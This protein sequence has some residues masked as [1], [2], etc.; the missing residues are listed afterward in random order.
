MKK[1]G[2]QMNY[3][4]IHTKE[5]RCALK[6]EKDQRQNDEVLPK[7]TSFL[8]LDPENSILP[9]Q[10]SR[11]LVPSIKPNEN[12]EKNRSSRSRLRTMK[13]KFKQKLKRTTN[14]QVEITSDNE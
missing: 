14:E 6:Y 10:I 13:D 4:S 2:I 5:I 7:R 11:R 1:H 3:G 9:I 12:E 8:S